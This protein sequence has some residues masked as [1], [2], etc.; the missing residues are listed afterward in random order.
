MLQIAARVGFAAE[1]ILFGGDHL[2][3][4][5]WRKGPAKTAMAKAVEAAVE[6]VLEKGFRTKDI[7]AGGPSISTSEMGA[8]VLA[9]LA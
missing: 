7:A 1:N 9:A 4:N 5:P 6:S 3:P 8:K 2:G